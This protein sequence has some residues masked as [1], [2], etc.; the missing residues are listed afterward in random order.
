MKAQIVSLAGKKVSE[1]ELPRQFS[2]SVDMGLIKRAVLAIQS[3]SIQT[4]YTKVTAGRDNTAVYIGARGKPQQH[5][6]INTEHARKPRLKN[7]RSLLSG[8]VAS[9]PATVGGPKAH[10]PK[11]AKIWEEKINRKEKRKATES[12]IAATADAALVKERGHRFK[13]GTA[14]PIIVEAKLEELGKTSDVK[15]TFEA[16]GIWEDVEKAKDKK[17]PRAGKGKKRGRSHKKR[18]SVLIVAGNAEKIYLAARNLE[19]VDIISLKNLNANYLAP[20]T[21]PGR[22]TVWTE[23]AVKGLANPVKQK[24][25]VKEAKPVKETVKQPAKEVAKPVKAAVKKKIEAKA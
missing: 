15:K 12:A 16:L 22:L 20:G 19:G 3:A 8:Q 6:I 2:A 7:R 23:N 11:A 21:L 10:P 24:Q 5:R 1:M 4:S 13:E 14:F 25:A 17:T 9:I 18:K